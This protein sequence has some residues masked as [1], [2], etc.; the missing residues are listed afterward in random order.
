MWYEHIHR[1]VLAGELVRG[2]NVLDAACGEGYG[3]HM[4]A[5]KAAAV[6]GVDISAQVVTHA[7]ARYQAANLSFR[8][9]DCRHLP[10]DDG[11]FDCIVSFETVEHMDN[12]EQLLRE[13]RRVLGADGFLLI[14][15]P[16]KAVYTDQL[17]NDNPHHVRE[18]YRHEFEGLLAREFPAV[19][20]FGHKLAFHSM[21][22]PLDT[23]QDS[24]TTPGNGGAVHREHQ[25]VSSAQPAPTA[26]P[27]Y[28][29]ALCAAHKEFLP[30]LPDHLWLFDDAAESV[31]RHYLHEIRKN[32]QAGEILADRD[33]EIAQLRA[34]LQR[35][36]DQQAPELRSWWHRLLGRS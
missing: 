22:W 8:V 4:L 34:A 23:R 29:I 21:I 27:A 35:A 1:Y 26:D 18:L 6:T 15:S 20:M 24:V 5:A 32:M 10:F 31:Y 11:Q 7:T 9:A 2:R 14:S 25:G 30:Q 12:Q 19:R 13:F 17:G 16:D 33:R 36:D 3:A 28:L